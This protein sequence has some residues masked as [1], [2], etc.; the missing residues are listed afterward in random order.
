MRDV[1]AQSSLL[2]AFLVD[3]DFTDVNITGQTPVVWSAASYPKGIN[4]AGDVV[5]SS[6]ATLTIEAGVVV[7]FVEMGR[8]VVRPGG[9]LNLHGTLTS[10]CGKTWRGVEVWGNSIASQYPDPTSIP[11]YAQ[12]RLLASGAQSRIE[13]A[14][15]AVL[16][17]PTFDKSG[18]IVIC[19]DTKFLNNRVGVRFTPYENKFPTLPG[20]KAN[21]LSRFVG[22]SFLTDGFYPHEIQFSAFLDLD[23]VQKLFVLKNMGIGA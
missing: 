8:L 10:Q 22:C 6:G 4:I 1:I 9:T 5:I 11:Y 20:K 15:I 23:H 2:Q 18:G 3:F 12:G 14:E 21:N 19:E 16:V 13:N 17:G 7:R